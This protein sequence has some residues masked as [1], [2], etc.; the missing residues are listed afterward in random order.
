MEN[1]QVKALGCQVLNHLLGAQGSVSLPLKVAAVLLHLL[2]LLG[3]LLAD[4]CPFAEL[5]HLVLYRS[6]DGG[7]KVRVP[8]SVEP[9]GV[10]VPLCTTPRDHGGL[11]LGGV[12]VLGALLHS[13]PRGFKGLEELVGEYPVVAAVQGLQRVLGALL[14]TA[15]QDLGGLGL[16]AFQKIVRSLNWGVFFPASLHCLERGPAQRGS[17][18]GRGS[19]GRRTQL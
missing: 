2:C 16:G 8:G 4:L 18:E 7:R 17:L 14:H 3:G 12:G 9:E 1:S 11:R 5:L 19:P 15:P 10:G 6:M 13:T